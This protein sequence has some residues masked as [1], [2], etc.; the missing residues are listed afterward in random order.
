[1]LDR[2]AL[3]FSPTR[4]GVPSSD[5]NF[6]A[7]D[8]VAAQEAMDAE[9]AEVLPFQFNQCTYDLGY[10]RQPLY[11]CLTCLNNRAVCAACSI[12]CHGEHDLVEL[13]NRRHFRCDCGTEAMGAGSCCSI[14]P[15]DDAPAN[16]ENKYDANFEGRFCFCGR[17]YDP[18]T[19]TDSMYQCLTCEDWIH[20][21]CLFGQHSD[22]N[23]SPLGEDDFDMVVCERCVKGNPDVRR[24]VE[25]YAGREGSGV[26]I[27]GKDDKVLGKAV[28]PPDEEEET[29]GEKAVQAGEAEGEKAG[30]TEVE[31]SEESKPKVEDPAEDAVTGEA[32]R[33]AE[34]GEDEPAA[35]KVKTDASASTLPPL[36]LSASNSSVASSSSS[37]PSTSATP[38][39]SSSQPTSASVSAAPSSPTK[40][41]RAPPVLPP[42]ESPLAML[43]KEGGRVNIYLEEGWMM[44][45]CRCDQCLPLFFDFPYMLEEE[46]QYEPPEDPDAHKSTFDLGME[47]LLNHMPRAQALDSVRAFTGLS[48]RLKTYLRPLAEGD[49]TITKELIEKFFEEERERRQASQQ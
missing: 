27:I 21:A 8:I 7:S 10:I 26:M 4:D 48:D 18:H 11:A 5:D 37:E 13:F 33:K 36:A 9:A 44:R 15:R 17:P 46:E 12:A 28:L 34:E 16:V 2:D 45:W 25:R 40:V 38:S 29:E 41:C 1:M 49:T 20:H 35:K 23:A 14:S 42:G 30:E 24:I 32:K 31:K 22:D 43:E 47:H 3:L 19:E 39:T 6:Y